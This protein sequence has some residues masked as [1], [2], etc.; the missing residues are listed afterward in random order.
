MARIY[1]ITNL[2]QNE[3][4]GARAESTQKGVDLHSWNPYHLL[5]LHGITRSAWQ[6]S[7]PLLVLHGITRSAW[8]HSMPLLVSHGITSFAWQESMP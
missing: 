3:A 8:Q 6:H 4:Q 1:A 7:M 5:V 2:K